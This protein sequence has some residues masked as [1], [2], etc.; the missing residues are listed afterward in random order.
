MVSNLRLVRHPVEIRC[1]FSKRFPNHVATET[2][3]QS[4]NNTTAIARR[5]AEH[6]FDSNM[7]SYHNYQREVCVSLLVINH[8]YYQDTH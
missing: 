5:V 7:T 1:S 8:G 4:V 3:N 2:V 6:L